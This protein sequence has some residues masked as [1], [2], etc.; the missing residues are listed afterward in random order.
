MRMMM[1][2]VVVVVAVMRKKRSD[3]SKILP[4]PYEL[5]IMSVFVRSKSFTVDLFQSHGGKIK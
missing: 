2:V 5:G 3:R 1:I 4:Q